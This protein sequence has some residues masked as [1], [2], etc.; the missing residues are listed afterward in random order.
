MH[1][2]SAIDLLDQAQLI[3][4]LTPSLY[5][6]YWPQAYPTT[7]LLKTRTYEKFTGNNLWIYLFQLNYK[8]QLSYKILKFI[9]NFFW[10]LGKFTKNLT[11]SFFEFQGLLEFKK[12][13]WIFEGFSNENDSLFPDAWWLKETAILQMNIDGFSLCSNRQ[14]FCFLFIHSHKKRKDSLETR[15][16]LAVLRTYVENQAILE[17]ILLY[18][19]SKCKQTKEQGSEDCLWTHI[20]TFL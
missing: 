7:Y 14:K 4:R 1:S 8:L 10:F 9:K 3:R 20:F 2:N 16:E 17:L 12:P 19:A 6:W 11:C 5:D 18:R 13:I 15:A